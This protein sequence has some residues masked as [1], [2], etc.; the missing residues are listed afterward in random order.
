MSCIFTTD[1]Y[2]YYEGLGYIESLEKVQ[3]RVTKL[4]KQ[5]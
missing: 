4:V 2:H 3:R 5:L 1:V